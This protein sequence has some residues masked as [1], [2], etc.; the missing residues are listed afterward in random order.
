NREA[1]LLEQ[2]AT[3]ISYALENLDREARRRTAEQALRANEELLRQSQAIARLGS[4][5]LDVPAGRW[6]SSEILDEIFGIGP[7]FQRDIAGWASLFH[8]EFRDGMV[9]YFTEEVMGEGRR[10]E[11]EY[12]IV[13]QADGEERWV[14]GIG[15]L[16]LDTEGRITRM[17]GTIQDVT[18]RRRSEERFRLWSHVLENSAEGIFVIDGK[19]TIITVNPAFTELTGYPNL[20]VIGK[21]PEFLESGQHGPEFYLSIRQTIREIG[22]WQGEVW[23]RRKNGEVFP[24]WLSITAILGAEDK[25]SH[26]IGV[27]ADITERKES[28]DRI[29]YLAT[30]DFLT[31]LPNRSLV[32]DLLREA[33]ARAERKG[34]SVGVLFLDLDRFKTVNDSLGHLAGDILLQ[35][36]AERLGGCLRAGDTVSR[37]GGDEFLILLPEIERAQ[38]VA[39]VAAKILQAMQ[40][41]FSLP[42]RDVSISPSIGIAV[43]PSDGEDSVALVKNADAAMY[44]A[45]ERGRNNYQ[46]FTPDMNTRAFEAL[47]MESSLRRAL[48]R[49]EFFL[50]Y[51]PQVETATGRITGME[52]LVRWTHPDLGLVLPGRFIS[53]AEERGL[54][55]PIGEWVLRT[56]CRQVRAWL[57]A[58]LPAVPVAVNVSALQFESGRFAESVGAILS[59]TGLSA[60]YLELELT[61]SIVMSEAEEMMAILVVLKEMGVRLAIDDFG[62][63]FS[64]LSYL[65]RLPI[66]RLKIDQSFVRDAGAS[67]SARTIISVIVSMARSLGLR[68]IAEGVETDEQLRILTLEGCEEVQGYLLAAPIGASEITS[69][70]KTQE[71]LTEASRGTS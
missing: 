21:S 43:Y 51:Q 16:E 28:A 31:G 3:D 13:R 62:T 58:G 66:G 29:Q 64:S 42:G 39:A 12:K 46:F 2:A 45:K 14:F 59:E 35:R 47:A 34:G 11:R 55:V 30:H 10:F 24:V 32:D 27:F 61:E 9:R 8:P 44:H 5:V 54:I 7:D 53:V 4:Y 40:G 23:S 71:G 69:L 56:A 60:H 50:V 65:A 41:P 48:D 1:T 33:V 6:S 49:D 67:P 63:G 26:F 17:V 37:L 15:E 38:D 18:E 52:A 25:P 57:D 36:V 70:L 68:V 20:E 22:R 19:G